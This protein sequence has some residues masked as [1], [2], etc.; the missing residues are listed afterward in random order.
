MFVLQPSTHAPSP[1]LTLPTHQDLSLPRPLLSLS[2][3]HRPLRD[4]AGNESGSAT[5]DKPPGLGG[6]TCNSSAAAAWDQG[7][8]G[9]SVQCVH[10]HSYEVQL[11]LEFCDKVGHN[12]V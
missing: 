7:S 12:I 8:P 9:P 3:P 1:L 11:V 6:A 10:V 2:L 4:S 5:R